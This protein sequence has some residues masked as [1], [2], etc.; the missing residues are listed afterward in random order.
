MS[1]L[2]L[3]HIYGC[4]YKKEFLATVDEN[5]FPGTFVMKIGNPFLGLYKDLIIKNIPEY[6]FLIMQEEYPLDSIIKAS[7]EINKKFKQIFDAVVG[8]IYVSGRVYPI[9]RIK[10]IDKRLTIEKVQEHFL[11]KGFHFSRNVQSIEAKGVIK[12]KKYFSL[13]EVDEG[14]YFDK[15]VPELAYFKIPYQIEW[16]LFEDITNRVKVNV[17][18]GKFDAAIGAF[19]Y[20]EEVEYIIRIL[21]LK[22]N[23]NNL[24]MIKKQYLKLIEEPNLLK[25]KVN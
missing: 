13:E 9:I 22:R 3:E 1:T 14:I 16:D 17:A 5:I 23:V 25:T 19:W 7:E 21:K 2:N 20:G 6:Y 18:L 24:Q 10:K 15:Q 12:L 4:I 11:N 8:E